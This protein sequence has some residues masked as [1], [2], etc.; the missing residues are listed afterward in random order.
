MLGGIASGPHSCSAAQLLDRAKSKAATETETLD[1]SACRMG[2]EANAMER[3]NWPISSVSSVT[4]QSARI[5]A[6]HKECICQHDLTAAILRFIT[7]KR[8][9][10]K[11]FLTAAALSKAMTSCPDSVSVSLIDPIQSNTTAKPEFLH[12]AL[13]L[14]RRSQLATRAPGGPQRVLPSLPAQPSCYAQV[15]PLGVPS[16][17]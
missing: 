3:E 14:L 15:P 5:G 16:I 12:Q 7:L 13:C 2:S 6:I 4:G 11:N 9:L 17:P 10:L 8:A 1:R